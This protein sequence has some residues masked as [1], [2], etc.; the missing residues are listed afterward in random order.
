MTKE[1]PFFF[2]LNSS[3]SRGVAPCIKIYKIVALNDFVEP[4]INSNCFRR[5]YI[6]M[7][8]Y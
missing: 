6:A 8:T 4:A 3:V 2:F 5:V 1:F 7:A